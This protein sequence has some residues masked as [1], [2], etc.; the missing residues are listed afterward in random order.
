MATYKVVPGPSQISTQG[1]GA[2]QQAAAAYQKIIEQETAAGWHFVCFDSTTVHNTS[3][4]CST[5]TFNMKL[6]VFSR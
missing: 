6:L 4:G 2:A 1:Q 3:C 5:S